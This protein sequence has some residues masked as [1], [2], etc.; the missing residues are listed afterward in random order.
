VLLILK[1]IKS[2]I[3]KRINWFKAAL[4]SDS[5]CQVSWQ[6]I[7]IGNNFI[8]KEGC[9]I[10]G[11]SVI[12]CSDG[13]VDLGKNCRIRSGSKLNSWGGFIKLG[14]NI[15]I[16]SGVVILGTGGIVIGDN[17]RVASNTVITSS[18]HIFSNKDKSIIEQGITSKGIKIQEDVWIG[19]NVTIL[20]GVNI[21]R[22]SI[23]AAGA[24]INSDVSPYSIVGGVPAKFI[25][26]R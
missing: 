20:D 22:G 16:N 1:S 11:G 6:S 7:F 10:E 25:K 21:G 23:V 8:M 13:R 18:N 9:I 2:L 26:N 4:K 24:V 3:G 12:E 5:S 14:A 17:T 15:S 19:A